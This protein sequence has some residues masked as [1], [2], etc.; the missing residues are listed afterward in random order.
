M[1]TTEIIITIFLFLIAI[2]SFVIS[3]L[4]FREKGIL[5]N[6]AYFYASKKERKK[7]NKKP[8]YKQSGIVFLLIG[9]IFL[10]NAIEMI[11]KTGWLFYMILIVAFIAIIYAIISSIKR[12]KNK[13]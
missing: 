2:G 10:I 13:E 9:S 7:M 8:H 12:N 3:Y 11:L 5:I 4:Q 1:K 6:N